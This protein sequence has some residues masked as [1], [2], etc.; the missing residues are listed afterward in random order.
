MHARPMGSGPMTVHW[1]CAP[2]GV[3][4]V[5]TMVFAGDS[6]RDSVPLDLNV[7]ADDCCWTCLARLEFQL[8]EILHMKRSVI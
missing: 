1:T 5:Y 8:T 4:A 7:R 2:T 3:V 6:K